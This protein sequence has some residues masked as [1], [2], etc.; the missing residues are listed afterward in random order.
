MCMQ[1]LQKIRG[2]KVDVTKEFETMVYQTTQSREMQ[3]SFS[4]AFQK[5]YLP[6]HIMSFV[7]AIG[8]Q[9]TGINAIM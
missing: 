9:L 6:Y 3:T 2:R 1:N 5:C 8:Q 4:F 7:I